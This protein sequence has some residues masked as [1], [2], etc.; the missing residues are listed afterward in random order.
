MGDRARRLAGSGA[1]TTYNRS[2]KLQTGE[3]RPKHILRGGGRLVKTIRFLNPFPPRPLAAPGAGAPGGAGR[4]GIPLAFSQPVQHPG[5]SPAEEPG[6]WGRFT[7]ALVKR[8]EPMLGG[9]PDLGA[10][11]VSPG[12]FG[13]DPFPAG[14]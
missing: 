12:S 4:V 2:S 13:G 6:R 8:P 9:F 3:C 1:G 10:S 7:D 5:E 14:P 11:P